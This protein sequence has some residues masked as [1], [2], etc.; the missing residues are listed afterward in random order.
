VD[1]KCNVG[2]PCAHRNCHDNS[3]PIPDG[4]STKSKSPI[5]APVGIRKIDA[6]SNYDQKRRGREGQ[7]AKQ[8]PTGPQTSFFINKGWLTTEN[9]ISIFAEVIRVS[10]SVGETGKYD[11]HLAVDRD[12]GVE[13]DHVKDYSHEGAHA[14]QGINLLRG[15]MTIIN[16]SDPVKCDRKVG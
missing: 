4:D 8:L 14:C 10:S 5:S 2:S 3:V 9:L 13:S 7:G 1:K 16:L 6:Q 15:M 11:T 12:R